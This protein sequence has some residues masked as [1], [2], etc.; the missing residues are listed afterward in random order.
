MIEIL[1]FGDSNTYG[2]T[3]D[4]K[5]RYGRDIRYP[6]VLQ[7][8]LGDGYYVAEDG[9]VGRTAA[10]PDS[11]R[12]GRSALE[13]L[14]LSIESHGPVQYIILMLGTNDCK[15]D[16]TR[17]AEDV[18]TG[19]DQL[20]RL[21]I[22]MLPAWTKI[23]LVAPPPLGPSAP[24]RDPEYDAQSLAVSQGVAAQYQMIAE[25][26]GLRF[27]DAGTVTQMSALDGEH[28]DPDGHKKLASAIADIVRSPFPVRLNLAMMGAFETLAPYI[29][30]E[31]L[32][33]LTRDVRANADAIAAY[34]YQSPAL[35]PFVTTTI[36]PTVIQGSSKACNVMP[37][38]MQA[39]INLRLADGDTVESVMEHCRAAVQDPTVE[40]RYQQANDPSATARRD[41]YGYRTVVDSMRRYYPDVVFVPSMTVGATDAHQYEQICDTCL[42]CS[43]FM[44]EPEEAASGVHGTNERILVRAYLQG[45]RVLIDLMEH[46]NL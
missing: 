46:A 22:G 21:V 6:G 40:L 23:L 10:F 2:F 20:V 13:T 26:Y 15:I 1:C 12:D 11:N 16:K 9:L 25:A 27:L 45:I 8:L 32:K 5:H 37:Q 3:P 41:G 43:P 19:M 39:V 35:F 36:A 18:G 33:T 30:A 7:A 44:A 38:D 42:R 31:P 29:T 24:Q 28:L 4:W 17:S 14:P 34:C